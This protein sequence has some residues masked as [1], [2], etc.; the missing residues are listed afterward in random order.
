MAKKSKHAKATNAPE[1][2]R[3]EKPRSRQQAAGEGLEGRSRVEL[4][5]MAKELGVPGRDDMSRTELVEAIR[6]R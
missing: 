4:Y 6:R 2:S 5:E 1:K 3:G